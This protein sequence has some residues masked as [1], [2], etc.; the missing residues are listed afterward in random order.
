MAVVLLKELADRLESTGRPEAKELAAAMREYRA[1]LLQAWNRDLGDRSFPRRAWLTGQESCGES[2]VARTPGY[3]LQ[4]PE[5]PIERKR[6]LISEVENRLMAGE[7][8]GARQREKPAI[9]EGMQIV[10]P[11][12]RENGGFRGITQRPLNSGRRSIDR[13]KA[14]TMM[15]NMTFSNFSEHFPND[16]PGRW[17]HADAVDASISKHNGMAPIPGLR[18]PPCLAALLLPAPERR[19]LTSSPAPERESDQVPARKTYLFAKW[20][21]MTALKPS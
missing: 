19:S 15:R 8:L 21:T 17:T 3:A 16:W 5:M 20:I 4:I 11:G 2:D 7:A 10:Q 9:N 18:A 14:W 13:A 1:E 6:S 12:T